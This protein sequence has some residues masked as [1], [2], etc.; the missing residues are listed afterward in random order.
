MLV[1][2]CD[3]LRLKYA[4]IWHC[5]KKQNS[6]SISN[7]LRGDARF[8]LKGFDLYSISENQEDARY[9]QEIWNSGRGRRKLRYEGLL[10]AKEEMMGKV[11][12]VRGEISKDG[13]LF[14]SVIHGQS[15]VRRL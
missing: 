6:V 4:M 10:A 12:K 11:E 15:P 14:L 13:C 9:W 2:A 8:D 5:S 1:R 3:Y 7:P